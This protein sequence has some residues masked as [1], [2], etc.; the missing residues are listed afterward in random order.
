MRN[1]A[2]VLP[3]TAFFI[4]ILLL[5]SNCL[6]L[7]NPRNSFAES[8]N[9]N[10]P[11]YSN[12][13]VW[14]AHP[15][16]KDTADEIPKDSGLR[17]NQADAKVD[18]FYIHP[19]TLLLRPKYWN[20]DLNDPSLNERTD[21]NAVRTQAS[22]FNE[23]SRVYA[24]RYRQAALVV[25]TKETPEGNEALDLA[26][27]DV[28]A[29][30]LHYMKHWNQG[31]PYII[32]SHSQG[33][34]HSVRLLKEVIS[35]NPEYKKNLIISYSVGFPFA[36]EE[37]GLPVCKNK[38]ETGCVVGWNSYIWGNSPG[39]LLERYSKDPVCV[40]PLSWDQNEEHSPASMNLGSVNR[41]FDKFVP[42]AAD[43]KCNSGALWIHDP[44]IK[45]ISLGNDGSLHTGDFHLFYGNI[46]QNAKE[47]TEVFL[48][49]R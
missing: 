5:G 4:G 8:K 21:K 23:I 3:R 22:A 48:K 14:S 16:K 44:K 43:A 26:F 40:N 41:S 24:P 33:T 39:R 17:E 46:R 25:F 12:L 2:K 31:R 27:Q 28:K 29:A 10:S 35:T 42:N 15:E 49:G 30:F 36:Q 47:R 13:D 37:T 32:A 20:G 7:L 34:R 9:L 19:T 6:F 38:T 11:N 45:I 18:T 1:G